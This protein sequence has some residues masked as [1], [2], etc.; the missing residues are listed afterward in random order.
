MHITSISLLSLLIVVVC[1]II[2]SVV[3]Y[4][5]RKGTK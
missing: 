2:Y 5:V 3:T 4:Y 1:V